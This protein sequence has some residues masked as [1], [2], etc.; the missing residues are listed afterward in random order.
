MC[1]AHTKA[2]LATAKSSNSIIGALTH[3]HTNRV[4]KMTQEEELAFCWRNWKS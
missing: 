4:K 3:I 2:I 1:E